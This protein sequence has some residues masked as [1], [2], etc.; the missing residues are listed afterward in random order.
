MGSMFGGPS[1]RRAPAVPPA[2]SSLVVENVNQPNLPSRRTL[3]RSLLS[4]FN[5][6][7][8]GVGSA[9]GSVQEQAL[10]LIERLLG[11]IGHH[12][13][14]VQI[15]LSGD[16]QGNIG[17][18]IGDQSYNLA[19]PTSPRSPGP[20]ADD[21]TPEYIPKPS[22]QRWH[23]EMSVCPGNTPDVATRMVNHLV[24]LL[25]PAAKQRAEAAQEAAAKTAPVDQPEA[26]Q[27]TSTQPHVEIIEP[28]ATADETS[29]TSQTRDND[30]AEPP[31]LE[32]ESA[33]QV[34]TS[35]A[36]PASDMVIDQ[37]EVVIIEPVPEP[38]VVEPEA[39][40]E[41]EAAPSTEA[42]AEADAGDP[43]AEPP[44]E[45]PV[46]ART[47]IQI[48][49]QPVDI[50]DSGIDLE[51]LQALPEE[52]QADVVEQH[53]REQ[54]RLRAP[55]P[56]DAAAEAAS[57]IS[58]EFLDA[59][60]PEIR[61][62]V[63]MQE[64]MANSRRNSA[65][66]PV[67]LTPP[68]IPALH[69]QPLDF[70]SGLD[71][72]LRD[73]MLLGQ[74]LGAGPAGLGI[75]G[76]QSMPGRR[77]ILDP[78]R[79]ESSATAEKAQRE[80]VQ[81][82]ERPGV[83]ALVRLLFF[84][85]GFKKSSLF[86]VLTNL[87]A[88]SNTRSDLLNLMLSVVQ[89]GTG[90]LSAVDKS[91]QQMS[92]RPP[93][94][95]PASK[96][97][98]KTPKASDSLTSA[99]TSNLFAR[100]PPDNIPTFIAQRCFEA[101]A[102]IVSVNVLAVQYFLT[103]HDQPVGLKKP[104]SKK[105]KGK[106]RMLP[107]TK[108]P[109]V[110]LLELL[111]RTELLK[112]TGMMES[113]TSL[114]ST[115]TR[116]LMTIKVEGDDKEKDVH[117]AQSARDD[118]QPEVPA[119]PSTPKVDATPTAPSTQALTTVKPAPLSFPSIPPSV[120][121]LVVNCLT[122]GDC[123]SRNFSQTLLVMQHLSKIPDARPI[124]VDELKQ[125]SRELGSAIKDELAAFSES[126]QTPGADM[127]SLSLDHFT[128]QSSKQ[129]QLLR[130]FKAIEYIFL[131][132]GKDDAPSTVTA[133]EETLRGIYH[134]LDLDP[135]WVQL[136]ES[137]DIV[138]ER[139]DF[140]QIAL[141]LLPAVEALMV[142][143]KYRGQPQRELASPT[144]V[145]SPLLD[146]T[147]STIDL[148]DLFTS[149]TTSHRKLLNAILRSNPSLLSGSFS[150]L[151]RNSKVLEFE[152]KRSWFLQKLKRKRGEGPVPTVIH[153]NVRRQYIF[154][155][156]F[157]ALNQ[158]SGD[159]VKYGKL[160]VKFS[161]EDGIDAGGVTREWFTVLGQEIFDPNYA[162]FEPCAADQQTYQPNKH[163]SVNDEHLGYFKFVGRVI[164]K[165]VYDGRLL[166]AYFNRAFYKQILGRS[167]DM[168]DLES[169]DP[170]YHKSLQ[171]MLDNDIT[172]IIDQE[173][174]IEDDSFGEKTIVELKENGASIPV[175][176]ENKT[177]YVRQV[178]SYRLHHS[179]RD[180]LKAFLAGFY[181]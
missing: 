161:H 145:T 158:R 42:I 40:A 6:L 162:L 137:L 110:I 160:S 46:L 93:P 124:I 58:A 153:L 146:P 67:P 147:T 98:P 54:E 59:L 125:R 128:P 45:E 127:R 170:E 114:L 19:A 48:R 154:Q 8:A 135:L 53:M 70:L 80:A 63:V 122:I 87:C 7:I 1:R 123:S 118:T 101:L 52:M 15:R 151:I 73:V 105:G 167:V 89:D 141:I 68:H 94:V 155:D 129:A 49:G 57:G 164:G 21:I 3:P 74:G 102:Y 78:G 176:E 126:L 130:L 47:F 83:A 96:T 4:S 179:I 88:N 38:I 50:T 62:E 173:F 107:Q 69:E 181:E 36:P 26:Q 92:L 64:A 31:V 112:A 55:R 86:K 90:D 172:G 174:T 149:F 169:I 168:R 121:R 65:Q 131:R 25:L 76:L 24:N 136:A 175:T 132:L 139:E 34:P 14:A 119:E 134:D 51:F 138:K 13:R 2:Q 11:R 10:D 41:A 166:D 103:E 20:E 108:F 60:P 81:L 100:M 111:D 85:E 109:I 17:L 23:E 159:E 117:V 18:S 140:E 33:E 171:W 72:D 165:A 84:P 29:G 5:D 79:G 16:D 178:V 99:S 75:R 56:A 66:P 77:A 116:P 44:A 27:S 150:L 37:E 156:S 142:I 9:G 43:P 97:T 106:D 115:V 133:D 22:L 152:N 104:A 91:F 39:N 177:E 71:A 113:L 32:A 28:I 180:Q 95:T 148:D 12:S 163:S 157:H 82:L 144:S 143:C 30:V 120:L 61:A 35:D